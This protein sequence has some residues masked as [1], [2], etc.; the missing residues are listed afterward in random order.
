MQKIFT[1]IKVKGKR[2][3][4]FGL[5]R[6][7]WVLLK[8]N[9]LFVQE[10]TLYASLKIK[11]LLTTS[12]IAI[13][14][15]AVLCLLLMHF[16]KATITQEYIRQV[17]I[18][19]QNIAFSFSSRDFIDRKDQLAKK[20][21]MISSRNDL[22]YLI[23]RNKN[24]KVLAFLDAGNIYKREINYLQN[25]NNYRGY[26]KIVLS[27][28]TPVHHTVFPIPN[29]MLQLAKDSVQTINNGDIERELSSI[30]LGFNNAPL[31]RNILK[32]YKQSTFISA[33]VI[34]CLLFI[35]YFMVNRMVK[36]FR[37]LVDATNHI[38][39]GNLDYVIKSDRNDELGLLAKAFN[40]LRFCVAE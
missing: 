6:L 32:W 2:K 38:S 37:Q 9:F 11:V 30:L 21:G 24:D 40:D 12:I 35:L 26:E 5:N 17:T 1:G 28:N 33:V 31:Q 18:S 22:H 10:S 25:R 39:A 3:T 13:F 36:P 4:A 27:N 29:Q 19:S 16:G 14:F 34:L 23:L 15:S 20:I 7:S 8:H